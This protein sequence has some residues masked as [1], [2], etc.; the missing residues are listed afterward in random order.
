MSAVPLK[1][2]VVLTTAGSDDQAKELARALVERRL[3]ACVNIATHVCS[4]YRWKGEVCQDDEKLLIIK[5]AEH[6][7]P[8]VQAAIRELHTYELPEK[9]LLPITQ[10]DPEVA[11]WI[12]SSLAPGG[13]KTES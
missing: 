7:F 4:I 6:L 3:A 10:A 2:A 5:T 1:F 9:L 11:A 13:E 12:E 8:Q